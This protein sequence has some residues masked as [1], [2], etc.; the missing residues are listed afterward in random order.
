VFVLEGAKETESA[1]GR[2]RWSDARVKKEMARLMKDDL[3]RTD[4]AKQ[5]ARESGRER[6][7][8]YQLTIAGR[9]R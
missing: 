9:K 8:V 1:K 5:V 7:E 2:E 3:S 4:A 6:R